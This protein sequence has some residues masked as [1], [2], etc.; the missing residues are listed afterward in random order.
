MESK[1]PTLEA[2]LQRKQPEEENL[3]GVDCTGVNFL[4]QFLYTHQCLS[5][6]AVTVMPKP[7]FTSRPERMSSCFPHGLRWGEKLLAAWQQTPP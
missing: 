5:Q 7:D 1:K 2:E 3:H 4:N 6:L